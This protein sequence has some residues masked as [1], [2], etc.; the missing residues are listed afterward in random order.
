MYS[1]RSRLGLLRR[2]RASSLQ[3]FVTREGSWKKEAPRTPVYDAPFAG[4]TLL[5]EDYNFGDSL[6]QL[7]QCALSRRIGLDLNQITAV[8][9]TQSRIGRNRTVARGANRSAS[10][11]ASS[12]CRRIC[13]WPLAALS[14]L[15]V[16]E[17]QRPCQDAFEGNRIRVS[18]S[19]YG[20]GPTV[21]LIAVAVGFCLVV[22]AQRPLIPTKQMKSGCELWARSGHSRIA[23]AR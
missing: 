11:M 4:P 23:S 17:G 9:L 16:S 15:V 7:N 18:A 22:S 19:R 1:R 6:A 12:S 3:K 10:C 14:E 21:A 20:N 13:A 8:S 2:A 5:R